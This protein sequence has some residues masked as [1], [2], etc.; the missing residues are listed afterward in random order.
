MRCPLVAD[1]IALLNVWF[2]P[3]VHLN[4]GDCAQKLPLLRILRSKLLQCPP[5]VTRD[6]LQSLVTDCYQELKAL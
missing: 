1:A 3:I 5:I 6:P 4:D 2:G